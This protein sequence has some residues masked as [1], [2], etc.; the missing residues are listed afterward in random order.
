MSPWAG[1]PAWLGVRPAQA[2]EPSSLAVQ[3][4]LFRWSRSLRGRL[5]GHHLPAL[6]H[7][8][9][10]SLVFHAALQGSR[11]IQ[12]SWRAGKNVAQSGLKFT[13]GATIKPQWVYSAVS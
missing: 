2:A 9:P 8:T 7:A 3:L 4:L 1:F 12:C 11:D 6:H 10:L 5:A 13:G